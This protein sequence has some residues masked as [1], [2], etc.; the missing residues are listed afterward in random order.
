MVKKYYPTLVQWNQVVANSMMYSHA[1][2]KADNPLSSTLSLSSALWAPIE[3]EW[4]KRN[5][6]Y[7]WLGTLWLDSMN[8]IF[9]T[10]VLNSTSI[11]EQDKVD[12]AKDAIDYASTQW[13]LIEDLTKA[14]LAIPML[15]HYTEL[16][17]TDPS[18]FDD[19]PR[20]FHDA[21]NMLT[22]S[23]PLSDEDI[24]EEVR[25]SVFK[26][27]GSW[28]WSWK[29]WRKWSVS[30]DD[31][32]NELTKFQAA[33]RQFEEHVLWQTPIQKIAYKSTSHWVTPIQLSVWEAHE[34]DQ[35]YTFIKPKSPESE[36]TP[37]IVVKQVKT[38]TSKYSG[39]AIKQSNVYKVKKIL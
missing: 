37:D 6:A 31:L 27:T 13:P 17:N 21:M 22:V 20:M 4:I 9:T 2:M 14:W 25:K 7:Q 16:Y 38:S 15:K 35:K 18:L 11:S 39:K 23:R 8:T 10:K 32:A 36:K 28:S 30:F 26:S 5:V 1:A 33:K 24:K 34:I 29:K 12:F 3:V 19:N